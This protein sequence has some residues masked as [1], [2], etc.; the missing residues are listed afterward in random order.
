MQN[1]DT[2]ATNLRQLR[3]RIETVSSGK[4]GA[5]TQKWEALPSAALLKFC[6]E[7]E[8][9]LKE[10]NW[11]GEGRVEFD[12]AVFDIKVDGQARQSHG[13]GV[14]AILYAAFVIA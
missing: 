3:E 1:D 4:A 10:W 8:A 11:E 2:Q 13:K 6:K 14:R 12:E 9:V 7:V 5:A